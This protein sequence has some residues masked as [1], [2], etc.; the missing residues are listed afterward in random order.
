[1]QEPG[2]SRLLS[3]RLED[4]PETRQMAGAYEPASA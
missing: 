4:A 3:L 1:M 2:I